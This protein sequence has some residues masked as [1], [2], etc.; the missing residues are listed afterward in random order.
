MVR[1]LVGPQRDAIVGDLA[2]AHHDGRSDAWY[3]RQAVHAILMSFLV[4]LWEHRLMTVAAL[5]FSLYSNDVF[6]FVVRPT[7]IHRLDAWYRVL[8]DWLIAMEWDG[9]RH[10]AYDLG[11]GFLTTRVLYCALAGGV[12]WALTKLSSAPRG[13][14]VTLLVIPQLGQGALALAS[15]LATWTDEPF[16]AYSS[17][18]LVWYSIFWLVAVPASICA[19]G[20]RDRQD[21]GLFPSNP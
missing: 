18:N 12:A 16:T 7:W 10:L 17:M 13:I 9:V 21:H 5:S 14:V 6:M 11:L 15:A 2:E 20:L 4:A 19:G 3:W 8:I 1:G